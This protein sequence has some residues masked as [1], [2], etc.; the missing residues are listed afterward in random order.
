MKYR[1]F[2]I[3]NDKREVMSDWKTK[4]AAERCIEVLY[5]YE[6]LYSEVDYEYD[7]ISEAKTAEKVNE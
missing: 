6:G 5:D 3:E 1:V 2:R 7:C 4:S